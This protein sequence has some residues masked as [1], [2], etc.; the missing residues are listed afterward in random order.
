MSVADYVN[1]KAPLIE[2]VIDQLLP[3]NM[4]PMVLARA[5]RHL[6]K[7]GGKRLRPCLVIAGCEVVGGKARDALEAAAAIE[8]LHTFSL[9]HDDIMDHGELRRNVRTVHLLWGEP[10]AI[11]A[12]D[13]LF[14]K[15]FEA[16]AVNARRLKLDG[17]RTAELFRILSTASFELSRGQALD[18]LFANRKALSEEEYIE[19]VGLKTGALMKASVMVGGIIGGGGHTEVRLLGEYG[20]SLGVAFQVQDDILGLVGEEGELGKPVGSDLVE[21]KRTLPVLMAMRMLKGKERS[22]LLRTLGNPRAR[23]EVRE[24]V[25]ILRERGIIEG[26]REKALEFSKRARSK[27]GGFKDSEARRFLLELTE[28][29]I[30]RRS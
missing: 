26:A 29:V 30:E 17:A 22:K 6:I 28:F 3:P 15:V 11:V 20:K 2:R 24:V 1:R 4:R 21:G 8:F 19:M 5:S 9:I 18:L 16:I 12:G 27:V 13:A 10:I 23:E 25:D 14:A 7:A